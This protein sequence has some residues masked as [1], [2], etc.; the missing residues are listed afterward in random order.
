[1]EIGSGIA[2]LI[3]QAVTGVTGMAMRKANDRRQL[4]QQEKLNQQQI[5]GQKELGQ[6]NQGLALDTWNKTNYAEQRKQ[7]EKAG[8]NIGLMYGGVG[9][10]GTTQGGSAGNVAGGQ[11]PVGGNEIN[12]GMGMQ[13]GA[14]MALL[15]AQKENIDADTELKKIDAGKKGGVDTANVEADT[16]GKKQSANKTRIE[17]EKAE[18]EK[19]IASATS[20][21][22]IEKLKTEWRKL[23]AE[24]G[25]AE[26]TEYVASSTIAQKQMQ[27][28]LR[29][30]GMK[31]ALEAQRAGITKTKA[32]TAMVAQQME[33]IAVDIRVSLS[34]NKREWDKLSIQER[35]I[36]VKEALMKNAKEITEF[37]TSTPQQIKQWTGIISDLIP[38]AGG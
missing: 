31:L 23:D 1:M 18:I 3:G 2:N 24:A 10:G 21:A 9:A 29:T 33:K 20:E 14:Q 11:A 19:Q 30:E 35:E 37:N 12:L 5:A 27:E 32:D 6:F 7:M 36:Y 26:A 34:Q 28:K 22:Q 38:F 17:A 8:L 15:K 4:R 16:E 25:T 13:A